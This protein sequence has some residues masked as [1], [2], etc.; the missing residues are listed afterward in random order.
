MLQA[1]GSYLGY[2]TSFMSGAISQ[3]LINLAISLATTVAIG[4]IVFVIFSFFQSMAQARLAN[5]GSLGEALNVME[6]A[7]DLRRIGIGKVII[8]VLLI[9]IVVAVINMILS[10]IP[11]LAILSIIITPYLVIFAQRA[12]GLLYSDI[13]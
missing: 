8:V 1:E 13:A 10:I 9:I 4:V 2:S 6:A 11:F 3:A 12:I 5:T 7:K